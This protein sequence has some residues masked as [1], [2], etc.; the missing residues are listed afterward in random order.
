MSEDTLPGMPLPPPEPPACWDVS[1]VH[2]NS[3]TAAGFCE[4]P[5]TLDMSGRWVV[6][7]HLG[8]AID[9]VFAERGMSVMSEPLAHTP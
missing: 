5:A 1:V 8:G 9:M 2:N 3:L 4:K 7:E 6:L